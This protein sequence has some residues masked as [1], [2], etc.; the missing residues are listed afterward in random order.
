MATG[1][2]IKGLSWSQIKERELYM[3][4]YIHLF[5][6]VCAD[7]QPHSKQDWMDACTLVVHDVPFKVVDTVIDAYNVKRPAS[8]V[9]FATDRPLGR[10]RFSEKP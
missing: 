3:K 5:V 4:C 1:S 10:D 8:G 6:R 7:L 2:A 9:G